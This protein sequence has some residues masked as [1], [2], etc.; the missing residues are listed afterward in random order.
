M[1][2]LVAE[3]KAEPRSDI[4]FTGMQ[5]S[6]WNSQKVAQ[7]ILDIL[8][9]VANSCPELL[10]EHCVS[11]DQKD[12]GYSFMTLLVSNY[13]AAGTSSMHNSIEAI[14]SMLT[15]PSALQL[16]ITGSDLHHKEFVQV[17]W[18]E[19]HQAI[20][21]K[22]DQGDKNKH[23][24]FQLLLLL[25]KGLSMK[26]PGSDE[27]E[28]FNSERMVNFLVEQLSN[29][30]VKTSTYAC[31]SLSNH[32]ISSISADKYDTAT[33]IGL[34]VAEY[35]INIKPRGLLLSQISQIFINI[36]RRGLTAPITE[37]LRKYQ[38]KFDSPSRV[39]AAVIC[40]EKYQ[41]GIDCNLN[42]DSIVGF[43]QQ[44][45]IQELKRQRTIDPELASFIEPGNQDFI[46]PEYGEIDSNDDAPVKL[47]KLN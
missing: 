34:A 14:I 24:Y 19:S 28:I 30:K 35:L 18:S 46:V 12:A 17:F 3:D 13:D 21:D 8:L 7:L 38:N 16:L 26:N 11:I 41:E 27:S 40:L 39:K 1:D 47:L 15:T 42:Q 2:E 9:N 36:C 6:A 23:S 44:H 31:L 33:R 37:I 45:E 20:I 10:W 43:F 29:I 5:E 25:F 32:L 4:N 22:I